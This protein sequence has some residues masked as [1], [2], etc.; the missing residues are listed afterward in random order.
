MTPIQTAYEFLQTFA[1]GAANHGMVVSVELRAPREGEEQWW[2]AVEHAKSRL[3]LSWSPKLGDAVDM[4]LGVNGDGLEERPDLRASD[5][6]VAATT[7]SALLKIIWDRGTTSFDFLAA[8]RLLIHSLEC[9]PLRVEGLALAVRFISWARLDERTADH[10]LRYAE[11]ACIE[12]MLE[13]ASDRMTPVM[14]E[15]CEWR[16]KEGAKL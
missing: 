9:P 7:A 13:L 11:M 5:G 1:V 14:R 16:V 10:I 15:W 2:L 8:F 3:A 6:F 12:A 4:Y